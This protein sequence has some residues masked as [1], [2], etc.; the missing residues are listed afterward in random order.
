MGT[1]ENTSDKM[2]TSY[3]ALTKKGKKYEFDFKDDRIHFKNKIMDAKIIERDGFTYIE[4]GDNKYPIEILSRNQNK[5]EVLINNVSYFFSVETP[6]SYKRKTLLISTQVASKSEN[7]LAPIPGKIVD[8][9]VDENQHVN[10]GEA[11]VILEA[12]KM[13][14]EI[15]THVAGKVKKIMVKKGDTVMKDDVLVEIEK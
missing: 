9:L 12:M 5:Y 3:I 11:L 6:F 13:Q 2:E 14:N 7:I 4:F 10:E 1:S 8:I 15:T